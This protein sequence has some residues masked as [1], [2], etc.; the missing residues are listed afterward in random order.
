[1][2]ALLRILS[3]S[4]SRTHS[5]NSRSDDPL[6][7]YEEKSTVLKHDVLKV[8]VHH[9]DVVTLARLLLCKHGSP[10]TVLLLRASLQALLPPALREAAIIS[11]CDKNDDT[12]QQHMSAIKVILQA[13]QQPVPS[14]SHSSPA[15]VPNVDL[16]ALAGDLAAIP[17]IPQRLLQLLVVSACGTS[18]SRGAGIRL[19]YAQLMAAAQQRVGGVEGWV[20]ACCSQGV[21]SRMPPVVEQVCS[22]QQVSDAAPQRQLVRATR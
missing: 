5:G 13:A 1:M 22:G 18:S 7:S 21:S 3:S 11:G 15:A 17:C 9:L 16:A 8:L 10:Q 4:F 2:A 12:L 20:V 19:S 14:S 6:L